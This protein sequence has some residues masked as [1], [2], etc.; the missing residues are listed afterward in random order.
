MNK[1]ENLDLKDFDNEIWKTIKDY[2]DYQISNYGRIKSFKL[3][4]I[5]GKIRKLTK[6][7]IGY[8]CIILSKNGIEK[9]KYIH[10]LKYET[11]VGVIPKGYIVH[12][13]DGNPENNDLDNFRL[14]SEEEHKSLHVIGESNYF[15]KLKEKEVIQIHKLL[16]LKFKNI[17]I[18]KIYKV[19]PVSISDIKN[20]KSWNYI[21]K[22][23]HK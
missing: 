2:S 19:N 7:T 18:S 17:E 14:M 3:D 12:H 16:K 9:L 10:I 13:I 6:M 4:K 23:F 8:F 22:Q 5:N 20:G 15:S 11:F 21:Y 1:Y